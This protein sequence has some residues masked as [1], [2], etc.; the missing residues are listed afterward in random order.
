MAAAAPEATP[1][2]TTMK[3]AKGHKAAKSSHKKVAKKKAH[4]APAKAV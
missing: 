2:P 3:A 1:A 4:K